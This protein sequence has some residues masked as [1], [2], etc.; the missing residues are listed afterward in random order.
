MS[1]S[2]WYQSFFSNVKFDGNNRLHLVTPINAD[3]SVGD[4]THLVYAYSD[5][6]GQSFRRAGG[7]SIASL[8]MRVSGPAQNRGSIPIE[9]GEPE[10]FNGHFTGLFWNRAFEPAVVY[11][12][13][14]KRHSRYR[15]FDGDVGKWQTAD[16]PLPVS[17]I[18]GDHFTGPDGVITFIGSK[19]I[20]RASGFDRK[21][22][23]F[24]LDGTPLDHDG[25]GCLRCV[26]AA[27]LRNRSILR[28]IGRTG[29]RT[30]SVTLRFE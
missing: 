21:G 23:A 10:A 26:D 28:G 22:R 5:D 14:A 4:I 30:A 8:P 25:G 16:Y 1:T 9:Q 18:R 19:A 15:Y 3:K 11:Q 12:S 2:P 24:S 27:L 17:W 20:Y 13:R 6:G 29:E 7:T